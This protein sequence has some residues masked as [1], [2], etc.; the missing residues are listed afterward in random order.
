M[1]RLFVLLCL[2]SDCAGQS[3]KSAENACSSDEDCRAGEECRMDPRGTRPAS[4]P[5]T[6]PYARCT[7]SA[8]C[9]EGAICQPSTGTID[10]YESPCDKNV[11]TAPCSETGCAA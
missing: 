4:L 1:R 8:D 10:G 9:I 5:V 11:C 3:T 6:C 2:F 7:S